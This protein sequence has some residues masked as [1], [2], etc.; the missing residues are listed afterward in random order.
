MSA[1]LAIVIAVFLAVILVLA[2]GMIVNLMLDR[3]AED[4]QGFI[5]ASIGDKLTWGVSLFFW[6]CVGSWGYDRV[7]KLKALQQQQQHRR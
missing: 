2:P 1:V 4:P 6:A 3:F 7:Q 5:E